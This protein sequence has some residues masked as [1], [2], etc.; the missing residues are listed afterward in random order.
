MSAD[1]SQS[2]LN[3]VASQKKFRNFQIIAGS[4]HSDR[5]QKREGKGGGGFATLVLAMGLKRQAP[6]AT[7][8]RL[9]TARTRLHFT[10]KPDGQSVAVLQK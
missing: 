1:N 8:D 2:K 10:C 6:L 9:P 4:V 7:L 3:D 5:S